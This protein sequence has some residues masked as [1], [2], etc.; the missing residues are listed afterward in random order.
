MHD[1]LVRAIDFLAALGGG[2]IYGIVLCAAIIENIFPPAPGDT[3]L[4]AGVLVS[5]RGGGHWPLV[6]LAAVVGNVAGAMLVYWFGL[7]KGR[8]YFLAGKGRFIEPEHLHRIER[9]FTRYGARIILLSRFLTGIRSGIALTAGLGE[10]PVLRMALYTTVST[11]LWNALIVAAALTLNYNWH[12][13]YAFA[14]I[15]NGVV[16][17]LLAVVGAGWGTYLWWR[18]RRSSRGRD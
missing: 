6:L 12:A 15:Y 7:A 13:I 18:G 3:V 4:F 5:A 1:V 11:L 10:V 2:W 8:R 14:R 16:F 9:W 17:L